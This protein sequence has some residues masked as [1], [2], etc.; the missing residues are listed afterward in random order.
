MG[1]ENYPILILGAG[2]L[3]RE[4]AEV[5]LCENKDQE[6][7]FFDNV[8]EKLMI[9]W[10][11]KELKVF[12][13]L[14]EVP[15][16]Y[17]FIVGVGSPRGKKILVEKALA[18]GLTPRKTFVSAGSKIY[19]AWAGKG[20]FIGAGC[21]I[22]TNVVIKDYCVIN[23]SNTIGHDAVINDYCTINPQSS[24]SGNVELGEGVFVGVGATILEKLKIVDDAVIGAKALVTK[25]I[26]KAGTYVGIPAR[27][28]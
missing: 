3:A 13:D 27:R 9:L 23:I 24:I 26:E 21:V 1:I 6:L 8:T 15:K 4:I 28:V 5:I 19:S 17:K 2:G 16:N 12:K 25:N 22:T 18:Q 7:A 11:D 20:G 14:K 10:R